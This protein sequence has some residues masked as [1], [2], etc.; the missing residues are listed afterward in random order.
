[1]KSVWKPLSPFARISLSLILVL[2]LFFSVPF[3]FKEVYAE[4]ENSTTLKLYA[5][6]AVLMDAGSG[7][8]LYEK[9]GH[10]ILPMAS[11]TKIMTCIMVLENVSQ[12]ESLT[13]SAYAAS[14]P[15]VKLYVKANEYYRLGDLLYSLMLESHNDAAVVIAEH[16]AGSTESFADMMNQKGPGHWVL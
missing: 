15:K 2:S 9:N 4:E 7:R 1:M 16:I 5:Q 8:I 12:D 6:S 11:T 13:V 14:M 3:S 10:E